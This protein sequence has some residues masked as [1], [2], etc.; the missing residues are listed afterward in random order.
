MAKT[1]LYLPDDLAEQVRAHGIS[2]S[3]VAQAAL[4][5]AVKD[6][7][8]KENAMTDLQAVA[9][10]LHATRATAIEAERARAAAARAYG[11]KWARTAASADDLE[12][13]VG[14]S[15]APED[16]YRPP[17][18]VPFVSAENE[19]ALRAADGT[20]LPLP[21]DVPA[22]PDDRYW[23][24]FR[25]GALEVWNAVAPLLIELEEHGGVLPA[26]SDG[27]SERVSPEHQLRLLRE[28][29]ADAPLTDH[30]RWKAREQP[31][32]L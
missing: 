3:E 2:I 21:S 4:R 8:I 5:Q 7:R 11:I 19:R 20:G 30:D 28:P 32:V 12:Y 14:Y 18:L 23:L 22:G 17:S 15:D 29:T 26:S 6:A 10:R 9:E 13:V 31:T 1:S 27:Y 25:L 24:D 16:F